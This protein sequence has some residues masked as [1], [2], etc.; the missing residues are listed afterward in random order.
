MSLIVPLVG[1]TARTESVVI[2]VETVV[3]I[4]FHMATGKMFVKGE[5]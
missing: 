2:R 3:I 5:G 1:T 4:L